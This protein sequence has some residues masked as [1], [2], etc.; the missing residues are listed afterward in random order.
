MP[1]SASPGFGSGF[2]VKVMRM[3]VGVMRVF[4]VYT[5]F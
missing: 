2:I 3:H 5:H 1:E 4:T